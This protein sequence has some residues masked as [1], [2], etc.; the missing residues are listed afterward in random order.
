MPLDIRSV[1]MRRA[2][3]AGYCV[4]LASQAHSRAMALLAF[5]IAAINL[6]QLG[7][8]DVVRK[9]LIHCLD[10]HLQT[11]ARRLNAIRKTA[12]KV[13]NEIAGAIRVVLA[14]KPARYQFGFGVNCGPKRRI[15]AAWI[16]GGDFFRKVLVLGKYE[17]P[18]FINLHPFAVEIAEHTRS[19]Y[20]AQ[21]VPTSTTKRMTVFLAIAV[22][23]TVERI[24]QPSIKQ[25]MTLARCSE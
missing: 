1:D 7:I 22:M 20:S 17:A 11:I 25:L 24:E 8:I 6:D 2:G 4:L 14:D 15:T 16:V 9:R 5:G 13:C 12:G 23:R 19:W 21:N 3:L 10:I 18:A